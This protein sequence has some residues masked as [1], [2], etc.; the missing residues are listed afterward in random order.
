[1]RFCFLV[2]IPLIHYSLAKSDSARA[3]PWK[4]ASGNFILLLRGADSHTI[5]SSYLVRRSVTD[6]D[7]VARCNLAKLSYSES[8]RDISGALGV[9][10]PAPLIK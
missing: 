8:P 6:E 1:M 3:E 4:L 9:Q 2:A 5:E 7:A 10:P